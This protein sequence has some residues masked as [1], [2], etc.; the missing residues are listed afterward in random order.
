MSAF[1]HGNTASGYVVS[2][3]WQMGI[4]S[5]GRLSRMLRGGTVNC[6]GLEHSQKTRHGCANMYVCR[7]HLGASHNNI[8]I[9]LYLCCC[10]LWIPKT[11]G[12]YTEV[13]W[14]IRGVEKRLGRAN[15]L[16]VSRVGNAREMLCK[17]NKTHLFHYT[18]TWGDP[19]CEG[20]NWMLSGR[21]GVRVI[22]INP[23]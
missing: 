18:E 8:A 23:S 19:H 22:S 4:E 15:M 1:C 3:Y 17:T 6:V 11:M 21:N 2:V 10:A 9:K 7:Q 12:E 20:T 14:V 13:N 5:K 16:V